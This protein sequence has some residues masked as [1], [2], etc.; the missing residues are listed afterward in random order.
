MG[1]DIRI[2]AE[3]FD[4]DRWVAIGEKSKNPVF[5][6]DDEPEFEIEP[7]EVG[8]DYPLFAMLSSHAERFKVDLNAASI[9]EPRGL[10]VDIS[11]SVLAM[12]EQGGGWGKFFFGWFTL[13]ELLDFRSKHAGSNRQPTA[14]SFGLDAIVKSLEDSGRPENLRIVFWFDS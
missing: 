7:I 1:T 12:A 3:H 4:D 8:R 6:F 2:Y 13:Q 5:G 10:P 9:S 11:E 14:W